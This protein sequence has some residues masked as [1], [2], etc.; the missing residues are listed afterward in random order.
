MLMDPSSI[1]DHNPTVAMTLDK[2]GRMREKAQD[3]HQKIHGLRPPG[4][5]SAK[6]RTS[7]HLGHLQEATCPL[8]NGFSR[9]AMFLVLFPCLAMLS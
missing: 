2:I 5:L 3:S 9:Q 1:R 7:S 4:K 6:T 8:P